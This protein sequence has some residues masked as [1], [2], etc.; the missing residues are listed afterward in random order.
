[1][2]HIEAM[3]IGALAMAS[4]ATKM[5]EKT[6]EDAGPEKAQEFKKALKDSKALEMM[7]NAMKDITNFNNTKF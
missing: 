3:K 2:K 5:I 7:E 4:E 1:M 6:F